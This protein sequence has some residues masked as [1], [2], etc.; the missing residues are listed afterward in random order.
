MLWEAGRFRWVFGGGLPLG[1]P[2]PQ[3]GFPMRRRIGPGGL[4]VVLF[5]LAFSRAGS[6]ITAIV[7]GR[8]IVSNHDCCMRAADGDVSGRSVHQADH[9]RRVKTAALLLPR[10]RRPNRVMI[11]RRIPKLGSRQRARIEV[12]RKPRVDG[13]HQFVSRRQPPSRFQNTIVQGFRRNLS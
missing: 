5:V 10:S 12:N 11:Y 13:F 7:V 1:R 3:R 4:A 8:P 2:G 9:V 6:T